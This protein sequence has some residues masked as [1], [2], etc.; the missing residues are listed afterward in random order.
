[1]HQEEG[2]SEAEC[3][4]PNQS[5]LMPAARP[6]IAPREEEMDPRLRQLVD[7]LQSERFAAFD[8]L[9]AG[10][11]H[12][13]KNP[14]TYTFAGV[15]VALRQ[16]RVRVASGPEDP[17]DSVAVEAL[18][19]AL[20]GLHRMRDIVRDLVTFAHGDSETRSIVDVRSVLE[21]AIQIAWHPIRHRAR[22]D[23]EL[24]EVP[25]IEANAIRL[26]HVFVNVL[27]NAAEAIPE[28]QA[29]RHFVRVSTR[30]AED[31]TVTIEIADSGAGIA[32]EAL[33]HIFDPFF[34]TKAP[35][36]GTG[37]GLSIAH[38]IVRDLGGKILVESE[39]GRGT[40]VRIDVP[41]AR[42]WRGRWARSAGAVEPTRAERGRV[43]VVDDDRLV[44]D[45]I[46]LTLRYESDVT[47]VTTGREVLDRLAAGERYDVIL[48]DLLMPVMTGMDLY[49][50]LLRVAP[51]VVGSVVFITGGVTTPRAR[52]F[53]A[54]VANP[55]LQK[56]V[57]VKELR[58]LVRS[59]V[60]GAHGRATVEGESG[61]RSA[62][63]C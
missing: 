21:S 63:S 26:G 29:D 13:L 3:T 31:G 58:E 10:V 32:A 54:G 12:E 49:A 39:I 52:A 35:G 23:K 45:A 25:P 15:E 47:V 2:S 11:A 41:C 27:V 9:I 57:D 33:P 19:R 56:P 59:R 60:R 6:G 53:L 8:T 62:P 51:E 40:T 7:K 34:T 46:A 1:M 44:G 17:N 37:L 50:E 20:V 4:E 5:G 14:M 36:T 55:C 61:P 18:E 38:G 42:A 30:V 48:S 28:G 22:L 43:L 24:A 16:L